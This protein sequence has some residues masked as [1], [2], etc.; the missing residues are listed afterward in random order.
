MRGGISLLCRRNHLSLMWRTIILFFTSFVGLTSAQTVAFQC[1]TFVAVANL[2]EAK[3]KIRKLVDGADPCISPD[4]K[5]I[6]YTKSDDEGNRRIA[7]YD[8]TT[9]KTSLV[10]GIE[11]Q[12]EFGAIWSKDGQTLFFH[13]FIESDWS[14]ASVN[15]SGGGFKIIIDK[16]V[17]QV[18]GFANIPGTSKWLCHD[19]EG[20][21]LVTVD[22][23][24]S[25]KL[26]DLPKDKTVEG[27]SMPARISVSPS[28]ES[29]LFDKTVEDEMKPDDDG[30]PSAVF[31][32]ELA[33]GRITRVTP[34]GL[35]ADGSCWLPGGK[36][37]L[38]GSYDSKTQTETIHRMATE[39]GSKPV[40]VLKK[41]R[42]PSVPEK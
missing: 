32:L 7:I 34:K 19:L 31:Q 13:H 36:E 30:P 20:F 23:A 11:G 28:G 25:V 14:L 29:A 9:G 3:P 41:A 26:V 12:N 27:L 33:T 1:D 39:P 17:R 6:A 5:M 37:F 40:L 21:Y 16:G 38:F 24:G 42:H 18:A 10:K 8:L 22:D 35:Y 15:S 4:G 2:S